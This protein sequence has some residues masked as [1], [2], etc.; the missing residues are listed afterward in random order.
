[1]TVSFERTVDDIVS[2]AVFYVERSP[3]YR[4]QMRRYHKRVALVFLAFVAVAAAV[5]YFGRG[6]GG[7]SGG[8]GVLIANVLLSRFLL[9][10]QIR[11]QVRENAP[12]EAFGPR[13]LTLTGEGIRVTGPGTSELLSWETVGAA[14]S[15]KSLLLIPLTPAPDNE[16]EI[17]LIPRRAF[18]TPQEESAFQAELERFRLAAAANGGSVKPA[19]GALWYRDRYSVGEEEFGAAAVRRL[20]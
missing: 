12:A 20:R 15:T 4:R 6:I 17:L 18:S 10:Q 3:E 19:S 2:G 9:R 5:S 14:E 11:Y 16:A 8:F 7:L 1:M 13:T